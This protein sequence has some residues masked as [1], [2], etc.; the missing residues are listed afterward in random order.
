M[1]G[2]IGGVYSQRVYSNLFESIR[3]KQ[4]IL[5]RW[6]SVWWFQYMFISTPAEMIQVDKSIFQHGL[7]KNHQ[8]PPWDLWKLV[9]FTY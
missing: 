3:P 4:Q 6:I 7:V 2:M 1:N 8:K 5:D 9:Y